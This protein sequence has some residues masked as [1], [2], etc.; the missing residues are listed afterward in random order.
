M[1][2][3]N[4]VSASTAARRADAAGTAPATRRRGPPG[5]RT[6]VD[7]TLMLPDV[8]IQL[9]RRLVE[10]DALLPEC[11]FDAAEA[12]AVRSG[13]KRDAARS[14]ETP[15]ARKT[16]AGLVGRCVKATCSAVAGEPFALLQIQHVDQLTESFNLIHFTVLHHYKA[17]PLPDL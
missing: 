15:E 17:A 9:V 7:L 5:G 4:G 2:L 13:E 16:L 12:S 6:H 8:R 3:I 1:E 14:A 10:H 11:Y